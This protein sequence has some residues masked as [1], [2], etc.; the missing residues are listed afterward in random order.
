MNQQ[1]NTSYK[2]RIAVLLAVF[3][4][5]KWL[6]EQL[7]SIL[8]QKDVDVAVFVSVDRSSD[9]SECWIDNFAAK[10][11]R[12]KV[13]PHGFQFGGAAPNFLR[14]LREVDL[15]SYDYVSLSD[16]DD[17]WGSKKL[18]AAITLLRASKVD[19]YSSNA[20]AFWQNGKT[21]FINKSQ[22]Q[23]KWDYFFEAAGPGCTYLISQ[24]LAVAIQNLLKAKSDLAQKIGLHDWF[25]YAYARANGYRWIIDHQSYIHYRQHDS[26]QVGM[27]SGWKAFLHRAKKVSSGWALSQSI[28][29][30][31][32]LNKQNEPFVKKWSSGNSMGLMYLAL[33][34]WQCRRRLRDKSLFFFSCIY[35]ALI[36][37]VRS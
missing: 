30:A 9:G 17:I 29:I 22:S 10:E 28:L 25:I 26:N 2:P 13:L 19:A 31:N 7:N 16:Q 14:L 36:G 34:S 1:T 18:D 20:L 4:G 11:S 27:N 33:H 12:I 24:R 15:D 23:V 3:N 35:M 8:S 5:V 21:A 37:G 32:L 6:P